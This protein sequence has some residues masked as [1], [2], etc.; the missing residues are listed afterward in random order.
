MADLSSDNAVKSCCASC[1][2]GL[3]CE[4]KK[5]QLPGGRADENKPE[6]FDKQ[7]LTEGTSHELEHTNSEDVATEI[8][9]DH[10]AE[11]PKYYKKLA[12]IEKTQSISIKVQKN[13]RPVR[14][15]DFQGLDI[16]IEHDT[17]MVRHWTDRNGEKGTTEM[18][19]PYGYICRTDGA[20]GEQVDVFVGPNRKS[21]CV[22]VIHQMIKPDFKK[23][24]EDKVMIGFDSAKEAKA[25]YLVHFNSSK[26]FGSMTE[27][28]VEAFKR[29]FVKK[30]LGARRL[31]KWVRGPEGK[32]RTGICDDLEGVTIPD[33][34]PFP[35]AQSKLGY[36]IL[37][38]PAHKSCKCSLEYVGE[39]LQRSLA[40]NG[41][42][43]GQ[44]PQM[45]IQ[46]DP[47]DVETFEGVQSLLNRIGSVKDPELMEIAS[48][49]WGDGYNYEG[50]SPMQARMEITGFLMDQRDL[51]GVVPA[52]PTIP[53]LSPSPSLPEKGQLGSSEYYGGS[54]AVEPTGAPVDNS[55]DAGYQSQPSNNSYE[56]DLSQ[57]PKKT[58]YDGTES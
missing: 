8:A 15:I 40:P 27:T 45:A 18:Q 47:T 55:L 33:D 17:G 13:F 3:T 4:S 24:D 36:D 57:K 54:P 46:K 16:S 20:D 12:K 42:I 10:L 25:A 48:K 32:C 43:V 51:L 23:Y 37:S 19:Y 56:Q 53:D 14:K 41:P 11:D 50:K 21:D 29:M 9:M 58:Q 39:P 7:S 31:K 44:T 30:A 28:D 34:Q 6:D 26:F 49:I 22:F 1:A 52:E 2:N 38:P 35:Y 5:D